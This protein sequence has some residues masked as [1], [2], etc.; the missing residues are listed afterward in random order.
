MAAFCVAKGDFSERSYV[1]SGSFYF[2]PTFQIFVKT[3]SG[4]TIRLEVQSCN[5]IYMVKE[6]I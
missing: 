3:L 4:R 1:K 6:K 2:Q 5:T